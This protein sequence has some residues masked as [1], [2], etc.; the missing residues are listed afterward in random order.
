ML[1]EKIRHQ[2][3]LGKAQFATHDVQNGKGGA[4]AEIL[5]ACQ[6]MCLALKQQIQQAHSMLLA[7]QPP[8]YHQPDPRTAPVQAPPPPPQ[9]PAVLHH[10]PAPGTA[11]AQAAAAAPPAALAPPPAPPAAV[12]CAPPSSMPA[13]SLHVPP[14]PNLHALAEAAGLF[15]VLEVELSGGRVVQVVR[16]ALLLGGPTSSLHR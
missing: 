12:H 5:Q 9:P 11:P 8:P 4:A 3:G 10:Q 13:S 2:E 15:D 6:Q 16:G 7:E 1:M 14:L